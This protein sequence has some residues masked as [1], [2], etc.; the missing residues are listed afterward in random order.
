MV[1]FSIVAIILFTRLKWTPVSKSYILTRPWGVLFWS[2]IASLGTIIP[3][4]WIQNLMP[5][6]PE[7]IQK[8]IEQTEATLGQLMSTRG[9]YAVV[10]LL[11]PVAEELVF[12]GAVLHS[13]LQWQPQRRWL[14]IL[15]SA[16][17]FALA[18][19]NPAQ[20]LHPLLI[21]LLLGWM[22]VRTNSIL[23]GI[24]FH[25]ANNTV[26]Y[27]MYHAYLNPDIQ[28]TDIFGQQ[29]RVM[30]AVAF[31]LL[32]LLP[33]IYQLNQRMRRAG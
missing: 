31:S 18:H 13:L 10:C 15:L 28:L 4:L 12:R 29:S 14:M 11:A 7:Y 30:L 20:A 5:E 23:P 9:G 17:L 21:G 19:L 32:I 2:V 25:W 8:Y 24:V 1:V 6:W 27:L 26:A 3:S 22:Y 16:L 33:A